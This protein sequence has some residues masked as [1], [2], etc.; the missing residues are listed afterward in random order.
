MRNLFYKPGDGWPGDFIPFCWQGEHH[1]FYLKDYRDKEKH[2]EG[3]PWFHVGTR[4]FTHF[5]DYGEALA[6]GGPPDSQDRW[7]FTGCVLEDKD[8][9]HI[10]YTGHN[11]RLREQGKPQQAVMH[12]TSPDLVT[13]TKDTQCTL[14]ADP[15]RY[16]QHDWRDPFVFWNE[17]AGEYWMLLAARLLEGP[18]DRRG[19]TALCASK[20]LRIWQVREPF[21]APAL[22]YTHEC[23]DLFRIGDWWYLVYSTFTGTFATRYAMSR[24]L[25]GPWIIPKVDTFDAREFYAAKTASDGR[26]RFAFGWNARLAD[27]KDHGSW[28]WGGSLAVHEIVQRPDGTLAFKL[29]DEIDRVFGERMPLRP[30]SQPGWRTEGETLLCEP[31]GGFSACRIAPMPRQCKLAATVSW[32]AGTEACGLLLHASDDLSRYYEVCF[33]PAANRVSF[34]RCPDVENP[35]FALERPVDLSAGRAEVKIVAENSVIEIYVNDAVA[36]SARG[37]DFTDGSVGLFVVQ[38]QATFRDVSVALAQ[39]TT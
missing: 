37:Y 33:E 24:T 1:L 31:T 23:P 32:R 6:R 26:R 35:S 5:I 21:W 29:P 10:F 4:D 11:S 39:Q 15:A 38:G 16:E 34:G 9:F 13:W 18:E 28:C 7:V 3:T 17:E 20:D 30:V 8:R 25:R 19:C 14:F 12:A 22:Y 2:G 27:E 36:L